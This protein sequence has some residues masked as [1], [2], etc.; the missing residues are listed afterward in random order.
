[1]E[2]QPVEDVTSYLRHRIRAR[3]YRRRQSRIFLWLLL[4]TLGGILLLLSL[5]DPHL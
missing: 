4:L 3:R 5:S 1:M 2:P